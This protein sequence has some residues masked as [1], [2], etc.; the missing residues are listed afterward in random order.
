M[1]IN[2]LEYIF[3]KNLNVKISNNNNISY[4]SLI[5]TLYKGSKVYI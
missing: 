3:K 1:E 5:L 4:K 2:R